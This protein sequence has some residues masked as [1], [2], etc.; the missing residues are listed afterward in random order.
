MHHLESMFLPNDF[1]NSLP[2]EVTRQVKDIDAI[3]FAFELYRKVFP[4]N[5]IKKV[6]NKFFVP[7]GNNKEQFFDFS[8]DNDPQDIAR[9]PTEEEL[10]QRGKEIPVLPRDWY[11]AFMERIGEPLIVNE[12]KKK[13]ERNLD[14]VKTLAVFDFDETL[15]WSDRIGKEQPNAH[16]LS[17]ES[18][19]DNPKETDW[20]LEVVYKAQ[21]LCSN[22]NVYCVMMTGRVGKFFKEKIDNILKNRNLFFAETHYNEFGGDTVEYKVEAIKNILGKLPNVKHLVMWEDQEDK[23]EKYSEEFADKIDF[24]IHIVGEENS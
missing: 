10:A 2:P 21:E 4:D 23:A 6:P 7:Y 14:I 18:L 15:F 16:P 5:P 3:D 24:N 17:P 1:I 11:N 20:N 19:P 9:Q 8:Y 13:K 22:P 12:K